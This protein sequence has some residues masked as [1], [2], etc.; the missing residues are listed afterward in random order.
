MKKARQAIEE[1]NTENIPAHVR[2]VN[3]AL[4]KAVSKGVIKSN[5]AS[6]WLSRISRSAHLARAN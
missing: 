4:D 1:K 3:K 5:T 2:D 6:R